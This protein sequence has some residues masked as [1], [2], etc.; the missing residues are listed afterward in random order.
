MDIYIDNNI[1][2]SIE[3]GDIS[4]QDI[5]GLLSAKKPRFYYSSAH[6]FEVEHFRGNATMSAEALRLNRFNTIRTVFAN[7]YLYIN[8]KDRAITYIKEDPQVVYDTITLTSIGIPA[9]KNLVNL[10]S[11]EQKEAIRNQFGIESLLLNNLDSDAALDYI[12]EKMQAAGKHQQLA[13]MIEHAVALHPDNKSF[14]LYN[15]FAAMFEMLDLFGYWRDKETDHSN[16]ARLWDAFHSFF[17]SYGDY[18]I[19]DDKRTR[20][21]ARLTYEVYHKT[22][23]VLSSKGLP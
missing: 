18:F 22:T 9:M 2:V 17:A 19:S 20:Y 11:K 3:N 13:D 14:G 12:Q 5:V 10:V 8:D 4:L 23:K 6:I 15:R 21:K 16:Y 7:N 1:L